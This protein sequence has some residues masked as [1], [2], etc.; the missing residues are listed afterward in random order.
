[1]AGRSARR[2]LGWAVSLLT[3]AGAGLVL[4]PYFWM[5][6][7]SLK[8]QDEIFRLPIEWIP[9]APQ[10]ANYPTALARF[11]FEKYFFNSTLV[12]VAVMASNLFLCSLAA[13]G[14]AK[15]RFPGRESCF[16]AMLSTLMLPLE[17]L[18]VPTFLV[19]RQLGLLDSYAGLII[20]LAVDAFG[21]F[22]MRQYIMDLPDSLIEAARLDGCSEFGIYWR[23]ILPNCRPALA[24]LAVLSF[25]ENWDQFLWP[26]LIASKESLK[27]FPLGLALFEGSFNASYHEMMAAAVVGMVPMILLFLLFQRAFVRG[28]TLSGL[29][30]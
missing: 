29:K 5:V 2:I 3:I 9:R 23:I 19:V 28:I 14:L 18:L 26:L 11:P 15:F 1:M 25:R 12:A 22:L 7:S 30:E 10:W 21:I 27:T 24:A 16:R 6:S 17:I 20:P 8:T 13:Y 4:L